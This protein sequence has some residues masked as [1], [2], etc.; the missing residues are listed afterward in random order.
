MASKK[1]RQ[2]PAQAPRTI[3]SSAQQKPAASGNGWDLSQRRTQW[4]VAAVIAVVTWMFLKVSLGNKLTNWDDP[5]YVIN[6]PLVKDVSGEGIR[7]IFATSVMGNYH[8]LTILSYALEYSYVRLEPWL[9]HF[10][11]LLLHIVVALLVYWL[12]LLLTRRTVAAAVTA[13]LFGVHPMHV[14]SVAWVAGR[15]DVLY[16]VFYMG[17]CIAY[18]YYLRMAAGKRAMKYALV[19]LL[20]L[21]SLLAKPV[22]VTLPVTLL[23]IDY[24]MQRKWSRQVWLEKIPWFVISV[25]FG[26][27]SIKDQKDF[28]AL[29][30]QTVHYNPLERIALGGYALITY[31][32][33]A[34]VPLQL[35][36][37][38]P[39]PVKPA[40]GIL[41]PMYFLYPVAAAALV[42]LI[43]FKC[44][45]NRAIVFG[46]LFFLVN[47]A[48]LLQFIPVGGAILADRY[49][50][51]SYMG[52]FFMAGML[53]AHTFEGH[54][55][56]WKPVAIGATAIYVIV[57]GM[58]GNER[59]KAWCDTMS[60]WRDEIEKQPNDAPNAYN[61]LGFEYFNH[62][63]ESVNPQERSVYYDSANYLLRRAI[64]LEYTFANPYVSLGELNRVASKFPEAKEFY[65]KG[66]SFHD[67]EATPNA[68][69]GLG[70]IYAISHVFDS[71]EFCFR[72]A[73][74]AKENFP[75]AHSNFGNFYDMTRRPDSALKE[76]S[77]AIAQ[78]PDMYAP[79][80]NRGRLLQR[81]NRCGEGMK[82][83]ETAL[84]LQPQMGEI[85]YARSYCYTAK[86]NKAQALHDVEQALS[87]G[88]KNID[89]AYYQM[90]R[91]SH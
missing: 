49:S 45:K 39:Y 53:V 80:L 62:F 55:Q 79:H 26:L 6:N 88:F 84:Q 41:A 17:A 8:P 71:S 35:S 67:K 91:S 60:L 44:R 72:Q 25:G 87:L 81:M 29:L 70:I 86:G 46:S 58:L 64:E 14:E 1:T 42:A 82:D 90:L 27:R 4:L 61:N 59:C 51:I 56:K 30:T 77:I 50:Y 9:Y 22:A 24:F 89:N 40:G 69:L 54:A 11:N 34:I 85:Y 78:N 28:D 12:V 7:N 76:Y 36:C 5:G 2:V 19:T 63:N 23:L 73:V 47:I 20:F 10:D 32:W 57:L 83:F 65:Y 37:F 75:E 15:K 21:C 66:L 13:L 52:L 43:Y 3:P 31:L 38:Y 16:G 74:N 18:V 48:L 33:K 68:Y